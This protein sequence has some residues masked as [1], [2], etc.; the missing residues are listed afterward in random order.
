MCFIHSFWLA[1]LSEAVTMASFSEEKKNQSIRLLQ[2]SPVSASHIV[3]GKFLA[4][5]VGRFFFNQLERVIHRV[6]LVRSV[7]GSVKQVTDF[8]FTESELQFTRVVAIEYPR[9]GIWSIGLLTGPALAQEPAA[10]PAADYWVYVGA[11]SADVLHRI[12]F[13]PDAD[14]GLGLVRAKADTLLYT[15]NREEPSKDVQEESDQRYLER[16]PQPPDNS[17][18]VFHIGRDP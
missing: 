10:P 18:V 3:M 1:A 16:Q 8:F 11:E 12:R 9:K 17:P 13:G 2:T 15:C 14:V 6:P 4:A 7:Y 5:G